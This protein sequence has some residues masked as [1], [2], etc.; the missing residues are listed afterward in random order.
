VEMRGSPSGWGFQELLGFVTE[1]SESSEK[2][3]VTSLANRTSNGY[4]DYIFRRVA[5]E[6]FNVEIS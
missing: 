1:E 2:M 3:R 6:L 5:K 4:L